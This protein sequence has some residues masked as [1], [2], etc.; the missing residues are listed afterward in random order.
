MSGPTPDPTA[1]RTLAD[2]F[3][4][5]PAAV[6]AFA[7]R[8]MSCPGCVMARFETLGDAAREY[9]VDLRLLLDELGLLRRFRA[10]AARPAA[11]IPAAR[12]PAARPANGG[13]R[14][15]GARS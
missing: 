10:P 3:A 1:D 11:A 9:R 12:K 6:R 14:S 2:L 4:A 15:S 5:Q 7:R 13:G 8:G